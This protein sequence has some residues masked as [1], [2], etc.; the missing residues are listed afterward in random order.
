[1]GDYLYPLKRV[2]LTIFGDIKIFR[3]PFFVV[4]HPTSF[5]IK[6]TDTRDIMEAIQPGDVV[7]RAYDD[8]LDGH[9]IPKGDSGCSHSGIYI[10]DNQL[11]HSIAEGSTLIDIIDFCRADQIIVLRPDGDQE[12]AIEHARKCADENI[13]YDF[14]FCPE[15]GKYYCHELVASC[16]PNFNIEALSSKIFGF[17]TRK[18]FIADSFYA[19]SHFTKIYP[20]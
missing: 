19:N 2:A 6:G 8:Y 4:Y 12:W 18:A 3:W 13:P 1:M 9:F 20:S 7:M 11:V 16:Y 14:D 5:R 17:S 15:P 10:G